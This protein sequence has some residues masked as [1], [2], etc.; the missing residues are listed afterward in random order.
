MTAKESPDLGSGQSFRGSVEGLA[1]ALGGGIDWRDVEEEAGAGQA[2]VPYGQGGLEMAGFDEGA[3][4]EGGVDGAET[5][6]LR[7]CAAGGGAVYVRSV[8]L[9]IMHRRGRRPIGGLRSP[10]SRAN[11]GYR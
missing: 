6:D 8:P 7:F 9:H 11:G 4:I 2:V 10:S 1:D 3:A 5:Q